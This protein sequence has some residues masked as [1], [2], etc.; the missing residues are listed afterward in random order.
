[1]VMDG[2][3][4]LKAAAELVYLHFSALGMLINVFLLSVKGNSKLR[5]LGKL[6]TM[7]G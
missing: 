6:F 7:L 1:M 3:D 4:G 2:S 5:K